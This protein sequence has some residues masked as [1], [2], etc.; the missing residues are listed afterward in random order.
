MVLPNA[1]GSNDK[2]AFLQALKDTLSDFYNKEPGTNI[3]KLY[4]AMAAVLTLADREISAVKNDNVL[5]A[6]IVDEVVTR[7]LNN[8]DH[9]VQEN[10]FAIERIGYT[11]T[12]FV[13]R[14]L[15]HIGQ[16]TTT[17]VL[18]Y[19]PVDYRAVRIYN[20]KDP[21]RVMASQVLNYS[22]LNNTIDVLGAANS[23]LYTFEYVDTGNVKN[24][25]ETM[26]IPAEVFQVGFGDGGFGNYG[27]GE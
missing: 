7:S 6:E 5:S 14:E 23:G 8:V 11:P 16:E 3:E 15:H 2:Q 4:S 17:V 13:R 18:R 26:V 12:A 21:N 22:Q 9:L 24:E 20:S 1:A 19:V 25:T 27:F 10:V